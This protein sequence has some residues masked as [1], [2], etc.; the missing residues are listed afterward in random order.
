MYMCPVISVTSERCL[1]VTVVINEVI[2]GMVAILQYNH[3]QHEVK[4]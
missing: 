3:V 2:T 1:V 4:M